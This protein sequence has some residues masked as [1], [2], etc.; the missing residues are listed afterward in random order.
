M[1]LTKVAPAQWAQKDD[2]VYITFRVCDCKDMAVNFEEKKV[3]FSGKDSKHEYS[4]NLELFDEINVEESNF[5]K[6]GRG[7]F[8]TIVKKT[9]KYW[10]RLLQEKK[11]QHWLSVDFARWKDEDDTS[12]DEGVA[13]PGGGE[14]DFMK[15]INKMGGGDNPP[16]MPSMHDMAVDDDSDDDSDEEDIPTLENC[17]GDK[18]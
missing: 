4:S 10:P 7:I 9:S 11:K 8:C 1:A 17:D 2:V 15:M 13:A 14:P 16:G 12:E 5:L 6:E 3:K 18:A